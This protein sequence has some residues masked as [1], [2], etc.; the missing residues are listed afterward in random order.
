MEP[1]L[2]TVPGGTARREALA[3]EGEEFL[4]VLSGSVDLD[5]GTQSERLKAGDCAYFDAHVE[6]RLI[7]PNKRPAR[8]LC[9]FGGRS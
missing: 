7:N 4:M 1:L 6:H 5:Y 2:L 9:V 3:H 8:V